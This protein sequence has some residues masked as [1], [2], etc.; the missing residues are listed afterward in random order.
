[1]HSLR[2][3]SGTLHWISKR[4]ASSLH[5]LEQVLPDI[6]VVT[7]YTLFTIAIAYFLNVRQL[8]D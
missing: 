6:Q 3:E 5:N 7:T 8:W 2:F 4:D 1:M